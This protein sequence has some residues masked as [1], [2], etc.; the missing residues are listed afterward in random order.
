MPSNIAQIVDS[1]SANL[2]RFAEIFG[3]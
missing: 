3:N 1:N 2:K